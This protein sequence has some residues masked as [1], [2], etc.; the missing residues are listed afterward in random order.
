MGEDRDGAQKLSMGESSWP[1]VRAPIGTTGH[2]DLAGCERAEAAVAD[3]L[4]HLLTALES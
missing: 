4:H 3:A 2:R 1:C